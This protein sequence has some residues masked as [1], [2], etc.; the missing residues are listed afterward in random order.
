MTASEAEASMMGGG[1]GRWKMAAAMPSVQ[2]ARPAEKRRRARG[3][4]RRAKR[5]NKAPGRAASRNVN[6]IWLSSRTPAA[7]PMEGISIGSFQTV[8][9][10]GGEAA[11]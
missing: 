11:I 10:S 3:P 2:Q 1:P 7:T 4:G 8:F 9:F 5:V 6:G